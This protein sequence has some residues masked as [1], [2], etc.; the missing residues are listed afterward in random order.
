MTG[1]T[2]VGERGAGGVGTGFPGFDP[3]TIE[4]YV[5]KDPEA[6]TVN[7]ARTVEQLDEIVGAADL[8]LGQEDI[9]RLDQAT[10]GFG[11]GERHKV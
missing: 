11:A 5:V 10:T 3:K 4:P 7:L 1:D 9:A 2:T 6:L 8:F